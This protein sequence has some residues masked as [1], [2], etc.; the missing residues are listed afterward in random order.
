MTVVMK[1][2]DQ[3]NVVACRFDLFDDFGDGSG[4]FFGVDGNAHDFGAGLIKLNNLPGCSSRIFGG[5]VGH[6]LDED[7]MI[8]ADILVANFYRY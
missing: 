2:A 1:I 6:G 7:R 5:C 3:G 8:A 4:G